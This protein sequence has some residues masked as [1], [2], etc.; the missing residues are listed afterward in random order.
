MDLFPP[1]HTQTP[2]EASA[3]NGT[4]EPDAEIVATVA[5]EMKREARRRTWSRQRNLRSSAFRHR[6]RLARMIV[7]AG[8]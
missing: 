5:P 6:H 4:E 1:N 7:G 8:R 2:N 3:F